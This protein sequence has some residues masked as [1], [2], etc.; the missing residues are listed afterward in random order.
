MKNDKLL[1]LG[2]A[3]FGSE[4][5]LNKKNILKKNEI[6]SILEYAF[7]SG[8]KEFDSAINYNLHPS[9]YLE[10]QRIGYKI[11]SKLPYIYEKDHTKL[12]AL[13]LKTVK[14]YMKINKIKQIHNFYIHDVRELEDQKK[15]N[16]IFQ[17]LLKIKLQKKIRNISVST[18]S[19]ADIKNVIKFTNPSKPDAIQ[20]PFNY[21]DR[22]IDESG[23][24]K[25]IKTLKIK[26]YAR[27]IFLQGLLLMKNK[28]RSQ[29]FYKFRGILKKWDSI[30]DFNYEQKIR[31]CINFVKNTKNIDGIVVGFDSLSNV[32]DFVYFFNSKYKF[33]N[34]NTFKKNSIELIDPRKW[35]IN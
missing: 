17:V 22:R 10:L 15:F 30:C 9:I 11:S 26:A 13:I 24:L 7:Q 27:S 12:E 2:G 16:K 31:R 32:K 3:Q 5:G 28:E 8:F 23:L 19:L 18:Y 33:K 4:Y 29:Y 35:K 20:F 1:V 25:K 14:N 34:L 6:K 21:L